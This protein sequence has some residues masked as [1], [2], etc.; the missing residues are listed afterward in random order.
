MKISK[1]ISKYDFIGYF[2]KPKWAWFFS[3]SEIE[4][5]IEVEYS[6]MN[7][8]CYLDVDFDEEN[9]EDYLEKYKEII[10]D[11][12]SVD[13][14]NSL[15]IEGNIIDE[16]SKEY[17]K[18]LYD[19]KFKIIDLNESFPKLNNELKAEKTLELISKYE[20]LILF[21]AVFISNINNVDI[22]TR[23]DA[24]VIEKNQLHLYETKA[25]SSTKK[26]HLLDVYFQAKLI[27][28]IKE[29]KRK[30]TFN[31]YLCIVAYDVAELNNCPLIDTAYCN[32]GKTV[33]FKF[34]EYNENFGIDKAIEYGQNK[35][36]GM[37]TSKSV[38]YHYFPFN[39]NNF[40][41]HDLSQLEERKSVAKKSEKSIDDFI[42]DALQI[43]SNFNNI[44]DELKNYQRAIKPD[45]M[46][47]IRSPGHGDKSRW[48]DN[49]YFNYNRE[50]YA[51]YGYQLYAY[52]GNIF[53][54]DYNAIISYQKDDNLINFKK[55]EISKFY[56]EKENV[57]VYPEIKSF[58]NTI[59][60]KKVYFD[61]ETINTAIRSYNNTFPFQQIVTQSSCIIDNGINKDFK[62]VNLL[63]DPININE[64]WFRD[65]VDSIYQGINY[66]YIVYNQSFE[67]NRLEEMKKFIRDIGYHKKI[68]CIQNNMI[69]L[70]DLFKF[71][72]N[73][74]YIF[75]KELKG[76]Y[77]IK[78]VLP[79]I[80]KYLPNV[81]DLT[82]CFDYKKL[83]I[84]N[85]KECQAVTIKRFFKIID[86]R[87][88]ESLI[89]DLKVYCENDV[90]AM[91]AVE[92]FAK[93]IFNNQIKI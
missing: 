86:D 89:Y 22:I 51:N 49:D 78:K 60:T 19:N 15:I 46:P 80:Q 40:I 43:Y 50:I 47:I 34:K 21:Q 85:G 33:D 93:A 91:I 71:S 56:L 24:I 27:E 8:S 66:S 32:I 7:Q 87:E 35:K 13:K 30:F 4:A 67:K 63:V 31:Y 68:N 10:Q 37:W 90:R 72:G 84:S 45:M 75:L 23:P 88:W 57:I 42:Q 20:K 29:L 16:K 3:N 6:K 81:F 65:V 9:H 44:L 26:H 82:K 92:Y 25:T 79:L 12:Q 83:K 11:N 48:K 61:F 69:D 77:S 64:K 70:A 74:K 54:Q 17:I 38:D 55:N 73:N 1:Y 62:C 41:N 28:S 39:I 36:M 76:F 18:D 2:S 5:A 53:Y 59:K 52:S 14:N 58:F